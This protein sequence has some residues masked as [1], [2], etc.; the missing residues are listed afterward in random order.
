MS[1]GPWIMSKKNWIK[2]DCTLDEKTAMDRPV[3]E[4]FKGSHPCAKDSDVYF[5]NALLGQHTGLP[6]RR[7]DDATEIKFRC[8]RCHERFVARVRGVGRDDIPPFPQWAFDKARDAMF[9][10]GCEHSSRWMMSPVVLGEDDNQIRIIECS[11]CMTRVR[12]DW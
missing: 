2:L 7:I 5:S 10:R 9:E 4:L 12:F 3:T 8:L 11:S 1:K 6:Y